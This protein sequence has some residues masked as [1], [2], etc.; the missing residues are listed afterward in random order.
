MNSGTDQQQKPTLK[1]LEELL[2][3]TQG[4]T[5][6]VVTRYFATATFG[7]I[8]SVLQNQKNVGR[9]FERLLAPLLA[10]TDAHSSLRAYWER[11]YRDHY[12]L[13][14][15]FSQ[16]NVP[17]LPTDGKWRHIFNLK[18]FTM[19]HAAAVYNKIIIAHNSGWNL[20]RYNEEL[21]ATVTDNIRTSGESYVICVRDEPEP[22]KDYLG[23]STRDADPDQL[24]GVTLLERLVH[25]TIHFI[26]TKKHLDEV[27]IT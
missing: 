18:G 22:D 8:Q 4:Q 1:Q 12:G 3:F 15:D 5:A 24:I 9:T 2:R 16:V 25:G 10:S 11:I 27:G 17:P 7:E 14:A 20:W 6:A 19:N 21:D 23:R 13:E 26:E